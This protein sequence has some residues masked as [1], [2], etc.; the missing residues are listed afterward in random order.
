MRLVVAGSVAF[1]HI[2]SIPQRFKDYIMPDKL[3]ILNI[4]FDVDKLRVSYGGNGANVAYGLGLLKVKPILL[5]T[6]GPDFSAYKTWLKTAG[7]N[8][9]YIKSNSKIPTAA[10]FVVIDK[11]DNQIW[12]FYRGAMVKARLLRL[13]PV[14][15]KNDLVMIVPNDFKAMELYVAEVNRLKLRLIFDPSYQLTPM[16]GTKLS[17]GARIAEVIVGN[18][19]ENELLFRKTGL[20]KSQLLKMNKIVITTFGAKGSIIETGTDKWMIPPLRAKKVVDP[21]GAGDAYRAGFMAAYVKNLPLPVCGRL[22]SLVA[23]YAVETAG[24]QEYKFS[25]LEL[26]QRFRQ[27]FGES[28]GF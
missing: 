26:R 1:D 8:V 6:V 23:V 3:H 21:V 22:G 7:V 20:K 11:D 24:T 17:L 13:K 18:D 15:N 19:Y 25:L 2:M 4:S 12:S 27:N 9:T 14:V 16:S 5:A 10:G 28:L